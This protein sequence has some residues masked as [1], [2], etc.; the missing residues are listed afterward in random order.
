MLLN[1][2]VLIEPRPGI[3]IQKEMSARGTYFENFESTSSD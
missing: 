1:I 3:E 2:L